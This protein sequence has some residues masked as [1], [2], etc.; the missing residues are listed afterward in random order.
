MCIRDRQF[1]EFVA[2]LG[3]QFE[4]EVRGGLQHLFLRGAD[5]QVQFV[6][7]HIP[8]ALHGAFFVAFIRRVADLQHV[9]DGFHNRLGHDA[10]RLVVGLLKLARCV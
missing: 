3:G 2:Q 1:K 10:V 4:I 6:L 8:N 7:A 5:E 9:A